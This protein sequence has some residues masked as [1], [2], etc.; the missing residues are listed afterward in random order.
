MFYYCYDT[1]S[2]AEVYHIYT[3]RGYKIF[4]PLDNQAPRHGD[5]RGMGDD[6]PTMLSALQRDS[7]AI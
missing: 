4:V 2:R 7:P 6:T 3:K 1:R 5:V